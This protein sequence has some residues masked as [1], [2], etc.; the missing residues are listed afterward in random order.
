VPGPEGHDRGVLNLVETPR[1][2]A[3]IA[4][5]GPGAWRRG[6]S[7]L[8]GAEAQ[9]QHPLSWRSGVSVSIWRT[10]MR[11]ICRSTPGTLLQIVVPSD[12][13]A[14]TL[15]PLLAARAVLEPFL[16]H[17]YAVKFKCAITISGNAA[18]RAD[19]APAGSGGH[20][21][22]VISCNRQPDAGL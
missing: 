8:H 7:E 1:Q 19:F 17:R 15:S 6:R 9:M 5:G 16:Y 11:G 18:D 4:V 13:V 10:P 3:V 21:P 14:S 22:L 20:L 12:L 2:L